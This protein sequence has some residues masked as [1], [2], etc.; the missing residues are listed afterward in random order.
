M[1]VDPEGPLF[2][3][4]YD[5]PKLTTNNYQSYGRLQKGQMS[6]L[7]EAFS[8]GWVGFLLISDRQKRA[9]WKGTCPCHRG[10]TV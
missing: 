3:Y 5:I 1:Q 7:Y 2:D 10:I 4:H 8:A 9:M 6:P